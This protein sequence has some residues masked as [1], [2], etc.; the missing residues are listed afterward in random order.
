MVLSMSSTFKAVS[1]LMESQ[2][3]SLPKLHPDLFSQ[4]IASLLEIKFKLIQ[5][6]CLTFTVA[7]DITKP[8]LIFIDPYL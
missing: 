1:R 7:G 3:S 4:M 5:G 2:Y 6:P 8:A